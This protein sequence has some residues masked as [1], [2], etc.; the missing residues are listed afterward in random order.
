MITENSNDKNSIHNSRAVQTGR[1]Q[2]NI[3]IEASLRLE[4]GVEVLYAVWDKERVNRFTILEKY[5]N[6]DA[7]D[8]HFV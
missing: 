3:E 1:I 5:K 4:E 6:Q 8:R 2:T 7:Y